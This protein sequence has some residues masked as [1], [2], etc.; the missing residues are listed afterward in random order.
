MERID[1]ASDGD[2]ILVVGDQLEL[3]VYACVLRLTSPVFKAML[4]PRFAEGQNPGTSAEPQRLA[5]PEDDVEVS[6]TFLHF[7]LPAP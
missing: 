1:V 6:S 4:G 2:L 7:P 5:L 3:R